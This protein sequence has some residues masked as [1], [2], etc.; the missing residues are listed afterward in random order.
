MSTLDWAEYP[1]FKSAEFRCRHC[2][3]EQMQ[4]AFMERLQ[5]LRNEFGPMV[6]TSGWRCPDHPVEKAKAHPGMHSTGMA[7][8]VA[9]QGA[10]AVRLLRL[11]LGLGFT[12]VGVQQKGAGRFIHLDLRA[13]PAIW[14]Y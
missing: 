3:K 11:A 2:G 6:I 1:S 12:G 10:D 13:V 4:P 9:V 14:S 5:S 7:A 8:D